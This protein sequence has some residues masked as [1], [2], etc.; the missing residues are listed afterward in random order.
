MEIASAN[1]WPRA[2]VLIAGSA[3]LAAGYAA[4]LLRGPAP[5]SEVSIVLAPAPV[6]EVLSEP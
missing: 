5:A 2:G 1:D 6:V 4:M 3:L